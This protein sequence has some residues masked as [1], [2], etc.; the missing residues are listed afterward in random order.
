MRSRLWAGLAATITAVLLTA[1]P[2]AARA[3]VEFFADSGDQCRHGVTKG[4]L[5]WVEG[6]VI[7][8][9]VQ[10][11]G[12]LSDSAGPSIC[13]PDEMH[14]RATFTAYNGAT[15]VDSEEAKA[16]D[17]TVLVTIGL[18]DP[19]GVTSIDRVVVQVCRY[20]NSPIGTSYCG[21]AA[22]YKMP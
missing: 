2:A 16:D 22:A 20:S 13:A 21:E 5:E 6:H 14:S 1:Q 10:V 8:P 17:A 12:T 11:K 3:T 19:T 15:V 4:T 18:S 7:R 9:V